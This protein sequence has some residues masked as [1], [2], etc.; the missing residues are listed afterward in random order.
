EKILAA[1]N[2]MMIGAFAEGYRVLA[3]PRYLE[4]AR[5]ACQF[6]MTRMWDGRA[7]KRSVKDG[8]ARFNAYLEDYGLMVNAL[9]DTYEAAL[10]PAYLVDAR[11]LTDVILER[12]LD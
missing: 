11:R 9:V 10:D 6:V 3:E 2:G 5:R 1:W 4:A 12:F 8:A 7:L